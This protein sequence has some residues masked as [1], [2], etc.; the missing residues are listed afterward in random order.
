[1]RQIF[2]PLRMGGIKAGI[3]VL[4]ILLSVIAVAQS[5]KKAGKASTL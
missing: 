5:S 1:M 2:S 3:L 4:A